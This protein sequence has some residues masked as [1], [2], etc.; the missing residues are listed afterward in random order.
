MLRFFCVATACARGAVGPLASL[1][2]RQRRSLLRLSCVACRACLWCRRPLRF[3]RH[4]QAA[5]IASLLLRRKRPAPVAPLVPLLRSSHDGV[6]HCFASLAWHTA[7][8]CGAVGLF[9]PLITLTALFFM[10]RASLARA[11]RLAPL[12]PSRLFLRCSS[13]WRYDSAIAVPI[14]HHALTPP[15]P[16]DAGG[17]FRA[18][19]HILMR[20]MHG[21]LSQAAALS[22]ASHMSCFTM[23]SD[24]YS[25]GYD[26][27][28][29][30]AEAADVPDRVSS[31]GLEA[32]LSLAV[33]AF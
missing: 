31:W 17:Q 21:G 11:C 1:V 3:A 23:G 27:A 13:S 14:P 6:A 26:G 18:A 5:R 25:D 8:A 33:G 28:S 4:I 19:D 9:A 24:T 10:A 32:S 15:P 7:R 12:A 30:D 16:C 29:T 22:R 20:L 2:T